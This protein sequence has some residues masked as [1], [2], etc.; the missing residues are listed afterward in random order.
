MVRLTDQETIAIS[1]LLTD[2]KRRE[3]VTPC[4]ATLGSTRVGQEAEARQRCGQEPIFI[5]VSTGWKGGVSRLR[6]G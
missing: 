4:G 6:T 5:V 1:L 2:P 3:H